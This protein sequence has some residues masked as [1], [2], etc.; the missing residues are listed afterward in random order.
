MMY[1]G[2]IYGHFVFTTAIW[3][4]F[5]AMLY[6]CGHIGIFSSFGMLYREKSGN[7]G[8]W[9]RFASGNQSVGQ[10]Y[11]ISK[12]NRFR[13]G[14][15]T[16]APNLISSFEPALVKTALISAARKFGNI[17]QKSYVVR[18]TTKWCHTN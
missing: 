16:S 15:N 8:P 1:V 6:F 9:Y 14:F 13:I 5:M 7:P 4:Y 11:Y 17:D 10:N 2:K 3:V 18:N 12:L